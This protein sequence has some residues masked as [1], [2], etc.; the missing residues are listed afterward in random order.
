MASSNTSSTD[1]IERE[2]LLNASRARVWR[3]LSDAEEFGNWFG[4]A[5]K[6]QTF[7]PGKQIRGQFTI[8]GCEDKVFDAII[9]EIQPERLFSYRWHPYS[10]DPSIDYSK[11]ERTLVVIELHDAKDGILLK[12]VESGFDKV[13]AARRQEAF[14]KNTGGWEW[15]LKNIAHYVNQN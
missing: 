12:V 15:Q 11:E 1:R 2:I 4:V 14:M 13:P 3:A 5:L 10:M 7:V 8:S 9:V 6:G